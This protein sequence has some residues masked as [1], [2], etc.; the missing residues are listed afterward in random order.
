M[1]KAAPGA[2]HSLRDW[3][4][5]STGSGRARGPQDLDSAVSSGPS[6]GLLARGRDPWVARLDEL[7]RCHRCVSSLR[8]DSEEPHHEERREEGEAVGRDV[9]EDRCDHAVGTQSEPEEDEPGRRQR[10][11]A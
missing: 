9:G 1:R 5:F 3:F 6:I 10:D 4:R 7:S 8:T 11:S 2:A